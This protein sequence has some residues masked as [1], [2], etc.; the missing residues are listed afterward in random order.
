MSILSGLGSALTGIFGGFANNLIGAQISNIQGKQQFARQKKL[1]AYQN[2]MN[3]QNWNMQNRYNSPANQ[4][5]RLKDAGLN[6]ALVYGNGAT[7]QA[8]SVPAPSGQQGQH[9]PF[10]YQNIDFLQNGVTQMLATAQMEANIKKT[11]Q[12]TVNLGQYNRIQAQDEQ[13]RALQ[14]VAQGL[15]NAKTKEEKEIWSELWR[16][17]I[18][19][20][21]SQNMLWKTNAHD[22]DSKRLFREKTQ[23]ER[24]RN[25]MSL[26]RAQL[27]VLRDRRG[28]IAS[29]IER[30]LAAAGYT[31]ELIKKISP[32][33]QYITQQIFESQ[34]R[35][36]LNQYQS[37]IKDFLIDT[38]VDIGNPTDV[39]GNLGY[40]ASRMAVN[41]WNFVT[42]L[43][44]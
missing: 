5:K 27:N 3:V 22:V 4:M 6:P 16:A 34:S 15:S 36:T 20:M 28:E 13:L 17:R 9:D 12:E 1:M 7:T 14:V 2:Q 37:A 33:I 18:D 31:R 25:E 38:G 10:Q 23:D 24:F 44:K 26:S 21:D 8:T 42:G 11:E 43:F 39:I 40:K 29:V 35:V 41:I 32:E 30:N 19:A